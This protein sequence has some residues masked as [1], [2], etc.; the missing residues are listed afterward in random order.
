MNADTLRLALILSV[1]VLAV[2]CSKHHPR[3]FDASQWR[4]ASPRQRGDMVFDL[5]GISPVQWQQRKNWLEFSKTLQGRN[6][7]QVLEILGRP[8]GEYD[9]GR[10]VD[11]VQV[12]VAFYYDVGY[13][14]KAGVMQEPCSLVI[15]FDSNDDV[16]FASIS[17]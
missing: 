11:G 15:F 5:L 17:D 16:M 2:S 12:D 3:K 6:R 4:T 7:T 14:N 1:L 13:L 9:S 10:M 8:N